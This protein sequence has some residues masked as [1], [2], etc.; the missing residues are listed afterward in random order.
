MLQIF[1][2]EPISQKYAAQIPVQFFFGIADSDRLSLFV[3]AEDLV[4]YYVPSKTCKPQCK[5]LAVSDH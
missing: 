4:S 3:D 5:Y 1:G 2:K